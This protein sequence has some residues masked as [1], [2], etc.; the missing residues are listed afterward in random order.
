MSE[1]KTDIL[2]C[3]HCGGTLEK[4]GRS[5]YCDGHSGR[6]H[7]F[8][9]SASGYADLSGR[10][11]GGGD[12]KEAVAA[13]REFLDRGYYAP[14]ANAI[15]ELAEKYVPAGGYAADAGC[16]EGYYSTALAARGYAVFGADLSKHA[17]NSASKRA[18][19]RGLSDNC[20]FAVASVFDMPLADSSLDLLLCMFA[21]C[22]EREYTR[23][24][25]T[26]GVLIVGSAAPEHLL[27]LKRAIYKEVYL[28]EPR[29]DMPTGLTH[30]QRHIERYEIELQSNADIRALF[31]MTPYRFRTSREDAE[32]LSALETLKTEIEMQ[33]DVYIKP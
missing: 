32:R 30:A 16:G 8:D 29:A 17:V 13:R 22:D 4:E 19:A 27:G 12:S 25:K 3:P 23:V 1:F 10:Q 15:C 2:K 33:F 28:N 9:L 14:A 11:S 5:L 21:P 7:C 24:L 6:R 18:R 26:G 31:D 20:F